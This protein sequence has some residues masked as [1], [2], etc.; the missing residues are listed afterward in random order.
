MLAGIKV[1]SAGGNKSAA[2][3]LFLAVAVTR[4]DQTRGESHD[5]ACFRSRP[6]GGYRGPVYRGRAGRGPV[7]AHLRL[8]LSG[9]DAN[10]CSRTAP[11]RTFQGAHDKTNPDG[12]MT[13][14]DPGGYGSL[15]ITKSISIANDGGGEA[16]I[17]V[18]GG[19]TGVIVNAG[20]AS[21]INLRGITIQGIGF[22][23][24]TGLAFNR[25][26]A[27]TITNCVIRNHTGDGIDFQPNTSSNLALLNT[28]IADNGGHGI[29]I[30]NPSVSVDIRAAI[31]RAAIYN[32]SKNG[33][34]VLDQGAGALIS[35]ADGY[36]ANNGSAG[37][38]ITETNTGF[39]SLVAVRSAISGNGT[40][41]L[42][43][44]TTA[45]LL[46]GASSITG[47]TMSWSAQGGANLRSYGDNYIDG[48]LD[49]NPAPPATARK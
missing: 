26:F 38:E 8:G 14:L 22:G 42:A 11:C 39:A 31:D 18:S 41:L 47:N 30:T 29:Q 23:G 40:G 25:G 48:N 10:D 12:E 20:A 2:C 37:L 16:S 36:V 35:V 4:V 32:N 9:N 17:L 24:G 49:L 43:S 21:Y 6:L 45:S 28:L 33:L 44:G 34:R 13:V 46:V 5:Q 7:V 19:A 15:T 1:L 3:G 27:L